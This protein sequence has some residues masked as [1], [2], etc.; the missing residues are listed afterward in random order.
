MP[1]LPVSD[2]LVVVAGVV[3][4]ALAAG[5]L[6]LLRRPPLSAVRVVE[7][8]RAVEIRLAAGRVEIGEDDRADARV[9]LTVRRRVGRQPPRLTVA[10]G[11]LRLDGRASEARLRLRLPR[12]TPARVELRAGEVSLWG[13]A[14]DLELLTETATIAG[15]ELSGAEITT[16]SAAGDISLHF[17]GQPRRLAATGGPGAITVVLPDG[18]YAV[19]VESADPASPVRVDVDTDPG[20]PSAILVRGGGGP[21]RV[22]TPAT[23]GTR[24]I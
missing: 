4:L 11:V 8:V 7:G 5:G 20:A 6:G 13:S 24:P 10:D 16:R 1:D 23:G 22:G 17:T 9:D 14:G 3:L 19:E 12:G 18:R 2:V 15:R 21:V